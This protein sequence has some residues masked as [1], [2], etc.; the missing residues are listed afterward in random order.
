MIIKCP[1]C[2]RQITDQ[3]QICPGCMTPG[4]EI[5]AMLSV[6]PINRGGFGV[7]I[8]GVLLILVG[9]LGIFMGCLMFGDIGIACLVGAVTALLSGI[10]FLLVPR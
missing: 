8:I 9:L 6:Q 5:R 4:D 1:K 10:G 7:K 3:A 2:G